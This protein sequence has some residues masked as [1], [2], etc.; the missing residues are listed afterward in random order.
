MSKKIKIIA[1]DKIPFLKDVL[2]PYAEVEYFPGSEISNE[3]ILDADALI[4]RTRTNCDAKLLSGT[5]VKIIATATIGVD[6]IDGEYCNQNNIK[7]L[8]AP[9]CNSTSVMQYITSILL[10]LAEKNKFELS[11]KT[12]GII[13]VGNVGSKIERV[14]KILGM[15]ILLNDPPRERKEGSQKFYNLEKIITESDII[16][17]HTPLNR[18]GIDKT[19]HLADEQFFAKFKK[20]PIIINSSRGEVVKTSALKDAIRK[21]SIS[22]VALDV[23]EDEP[24]IDLELLDMVDLATPHIAGYSTDGKVNGTTVCVNE[25][26]DFFNL[27]LKANPAKKTSGQVWYPESIPIAKN[28]NEIV[29]D[30]NN[31]TEQE[32]IAEAV[33]TTYS[34]TD[35]DKILRNSPETFEKQRGDYRIRREFDNYSLKLKNCNSVVENKLS[36]LGFK[37]VS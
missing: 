26:N 28:G 2:E 15:K 4:I 17:F 6:H 13:G 29:I 19:F 23:W 25:I 35:D 36:K 24:K 1:D 3:K 9:G 32:V 31:K 22:N 14:A 30:C 21:G 10:T 16:T 37:I 7:W 8:N 5:N 34:I 20:K 33:N 11:T 18:E 12:I 27:G